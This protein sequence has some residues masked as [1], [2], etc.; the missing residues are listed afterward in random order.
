MLENIRKGRNPVCALEWRGC[1]LRFAT[2]AAFSVVRD[3]VPETLT[4]ISYMRIPKHQKSTA[5]V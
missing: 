3:V 4:I 2:Q 1:K 5:N